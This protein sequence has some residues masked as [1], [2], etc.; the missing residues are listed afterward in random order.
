MKVDDALT[1]LSLR[2]DLD[3]DYWICESD[4]SHQGKVSHQKAVLDAIK[5]YNASWD[6][7]KMHAQLITT[8]AF[9]SEPPIPYKETK[10][11][12]TTFIDPNLYTQSA[13][14]NLKYWYAFLEPPY[15][16]KYSI[17]DFRMVNAALFPKGINH[18]EI[19]SW[20]TNWSD[21]FDA[22]HEWW[23]AACWSIYDRLENRYVVILASCTD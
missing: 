11:D 10:Y 16:N 4:T 3:I 7:N 5:E 23:G 1:Q 9:F 6:E 15:G 22:G 21:F 18:L 17:E 12:L 20:S 2:Y 13:R 19:L 14:K 8:Q